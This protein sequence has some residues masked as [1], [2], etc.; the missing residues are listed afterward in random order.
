MKVLDEALVQLDVD[1][2]TSEEAIAYMSEILFKNGYVKESYSERVIQR[3]KEYPTG[4]IG[5][6]RGIAI[7]HTTSDY[8]IKPAVCVL[9]P[10]QPIPFMMMGTVDELIEAEILFPMVVK[11]NRMQLNMLKKMM[12]ILKDNEILEKIY[13]SKDKAEILKLLAFLEED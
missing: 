3:E 2:K 10:R 7:P 5:Q 11:D 1:V 12:G 13:N 6:G 9:I 4:L 8:A